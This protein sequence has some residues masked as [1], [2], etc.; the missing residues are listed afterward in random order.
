MLVEKINDHVIQALNRL[1]Q[2]YKNQPRIT[3]FY[4]AI[5]KQIQDL[6]NAIYDLNSGRQLWDGT[7]T[8]AVGE[9]LDKLG[10]LVGISRNG[11]T[12]QQYVLFLFG[13]IGEN[14]SDTTITTVETVAGYLFETQ[15][16]LLYEEYPAGVGIEVIGSQLPPSLNNVAI[17]L[18]QA[19]LGAGIKIRF[20][21]ISNT[22]NTFRFD[23]PG[24]VG[25]INGFGDVNDPDVGGVYIGLIL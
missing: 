7:T 16:V 25:A 4:T 24:I 23:G 12:D 11:L 14:F 18:I 2:Q 5:I 3:G 9:Q 10:E 20:F 22:L 13:K 19:T 17:G 15:V 6:E 8:P 1:A 21:A